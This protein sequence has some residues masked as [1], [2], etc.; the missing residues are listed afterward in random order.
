MAFV[1]FELIKKNKL[2]QD[3]FELVFSCKDF[4][5][6]LPWQ[7]ITFMLPKTRFARAYSILKQ[8][9]ENFYFLI[10]RLENWRWWSK[11][12]CDIDVWT[13][14][15]WTLPI[16]HFL[17]QENSKNKLFIW[18]WTWL[19]PLYFQIKYLLE[20]NFR[21]KY[22]LILWN[23]EE[24]DLYYIDEL[25]SLKCD[26]FDFEIYLSQENNNNF[27][28]WRVWAF[29]TEENIKKFDEFYICWNPEMVDDA[30]SKLIS[31]WVDKELIF[32]E[33]Y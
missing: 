12:I 20:N 25:N 22:K 9:W 5:N 2:T 6:S 15:K 19:V 30:V 23:R 4:K 11:E 24:R 14:L 28:Y 3:V 13:V 27:K 10:K 8:D 1:D 16:W 21:W 18:T 31:L 33:K 32:M 26:N 17:V 29:L 7:F